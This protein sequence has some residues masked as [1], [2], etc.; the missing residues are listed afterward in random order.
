MDELEAVLGI[1]AFAVNWPLGTGPD[2]KGVFD[3]LNK[4]VHFF[5]R[6]ARRRVPRPGVDP[7]PERPGRA[8]RA[9]R[10]RP[11]RK[12][13]D[14]LGCSTSPARRS[15]RTRCWRAADAGLLRQR[16]QQ[17]RR[18]DAA[19]RLPRPLARRRD[20]AR[21]AAGSWTRPTP[22]FSGFVFK[23]QA[24]MDP[25]H[26]DRI[27]FVRVCSGQVRARHDGHAR[28]GRARRCG[29]PARTSC[30]ARTA[31]RWTRRT[32]GD[33]IGL[34]GHAG[35]AHRRHADRGRGHRLRRD[36]AL[37]ARVLRVPARDG[38]VAVQA[39]PRGAGPAAPGRRD[40]GAAGPRLQPPRAAA[41]RGRPAAVR[42]GA[43]PPEVRVR[44]RL[45]A[46]TGKLGRR[47]AGSRPTPTSSALAAT[48]PGGA[49]VATD[50]QGQPMAL[51]PRRVGAGVLRE[52]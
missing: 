49:V 16:G 23:I 37:R 7:R 17:L 12:S 13:V 19:R 6:T 22:A 33:V 42:G 9:E 36:P 24:N 2:F 34:V 10:R 20:R 25:R 30:S 26:R 3:R 44:R 11:T 32:P 1:K 52:A 29:C 18:A 46:R 50:S 38:D 15:T 14:E 28:A 8:R 48:L 41:R 45:A 4:Q 21:P 39:V 47:R 43:V 35:F 40:P 51:V 31:R 5:E 27:A